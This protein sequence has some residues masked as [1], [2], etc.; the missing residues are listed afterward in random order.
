VVL[1]AVTVGPAGLWVL[2]SIQTGLN[3]SAKHLSR[4]SD[5]IACVYQELTSITPNFYRLGFSGV[6]ADT[7]TVPHPSELSFL[8]LP[9]SPP[10]SNRPAQHS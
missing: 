1:R 7:L 2:F 9:V 3:S 4:F 6:V 10:T 8:P 5:R